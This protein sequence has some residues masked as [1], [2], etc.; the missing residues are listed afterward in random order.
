M[1]TRLI[2]IIQTNNQLK[3]NEDEK[4]TK[5]KKYMI[6]IVYANFIIFYTFY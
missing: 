3:I 2:T 5:E 4:K 6:L 1:E